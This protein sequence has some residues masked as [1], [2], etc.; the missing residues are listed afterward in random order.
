VE[1]ALCLRAWSTG[2]RGLLWVL[3]R[4]PG[5]AYLC[6]VLFS[7][8]VAWPRCGCALD[9]MLHGR[10]LVPPTNRRSA[11]LFL[12][13]LGLCYLCAFLSFHLQ[14][15][16]LVGP[17]GI[18][19]VEETLRLA[20]RTYGE[21]RYWKFPTL[22][23]AEHEYTTELEKDGEAWSPDSP[24]RI[25]GLVVRWIARDVDRVCWTGILAALALILGFLERPCLVLL[26][27]TY[28]SLVV[29][30][31][32]FMTFQWDT[33][34]LEAGFLSLFLA[35]PG[36][37]SRPGR[38]AA[39]RIWSVWLL[40]FLLFRLMVGSGL[41]KLWS[42]DPTWTDLEA[43]FY[44]YWTQPLPSWPAWYAHQLPAWFHKL[45]VVGMFAIQVRLSVLV[46]GT[47]GLRLLAF[48]GLAS[49][50]VLI[51]LT[52]NY[53]FFNLLALSLCV[54]LLDDGHL[55][56]LCPRRWRRRWPRGTPLRVGRRWLE[57][58]RWLERGRWWMSGGPAA[59]S[60][61]RIAFAGGV[62][63]TLAVLGAG[64]CV[65]RLD[66]DEVPPFVMNALARVRP[67]HTINGYGLFARM[68]TSRR[69]IVIEGSRDGET[70]KPYAFKWKPGDVTAP[71]RFCAPHMPRLDWQMWF[72]ALG[73][74]RGNPWYV[75]L[76]SKLLHGSPAVL[77]QLAHNPFPDA[78]PRFVRGVYYEYTFTDRTAREQTGAWW[79]RRRLGLYSRPR[80]LRTAEDP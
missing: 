33:L 53:G 28:L 32:Q 13:L 55:A 35:S 63:V 39:P 23:W 71:P 7:V 65:A 59:R 77:A 44:H 6:K 3:R 70:W 19:P 66:R 60:L 18:Y 75:R 20:D 61:L 50:Q 57:P 73:S 30:G 78:P 38:S 42:G 36:V 80:R 49:L 76:Q 9:R 5:V 40:R 14:A 46:F 41:S 31:R 47:R 11:W 21:E 29:V 68:T 12:R 67:F 27:A 48:V 37:W 4:I 54:L 52:G 79:A 56:S 45:S 69:E 72:A 34:L 15:D 2:K 10:A 74:E 51:A 22:L 25:G 8:L 58:E 1:A 17:D 16:A 62:T 64:A 24:G 26:W 43:L